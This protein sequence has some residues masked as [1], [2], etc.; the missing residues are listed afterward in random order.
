MLES[1]TLCLVVKTLLSHRTCSPW[2]HLN[3]C[4]TA[5]D[6]VVDSEG[7]KG[8]PILGLQQQSHSQSVGNYS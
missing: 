3:L 7:K 5:Y 1:T 4:G 2:I 8:W 6:S